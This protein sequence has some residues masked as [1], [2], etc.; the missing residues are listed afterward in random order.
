MLWAV[1]TELV[2]RSE[3]EL[4]AQKA[5]KQ[6]SDNQRRENKLLMLEGKYPDAVQHTMRSPSFKAEIEGF[7]SATKSSVFLLRL[8]DGHGP[9]LGKF[10]CC[11]ALVDKHLRVIEEAKKVPYIAQMR[12]IFAKRWKRWH[13]P[14]HTMA[15]VLDPCYQ[16]HELNSIEKRDCVQVMKHLGGAEWPKMKMEFDRWRMS[17][18]SI[19][20]PAVWAA[21][22]KAHGF[23]WWES[24]GDAFEHLQPLATTL[25]SKAM[26]ASVCEFN[27]SDVGQVHLPACCLLKPLH[28]NH[29]FTL[30]SCCNR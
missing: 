5:L 23:Q 4:A 7:I 25:L 19:F 28:S 24:F 27:W 2:N 26:S 14:V 29:A 3:Y 1:L 17:G 21:A 20:E 30:R 22:D 10:Y 18:E 12:S 8:V 9:I 15:Y 16:G 6:W 11:C 13:R